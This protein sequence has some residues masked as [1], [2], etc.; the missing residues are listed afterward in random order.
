MSLSTTAAT[1]Q[2]EINAS[3]ALDATSTRAAGWLSACP[4]E[5]S[6]EDCIRFGAFKFA[7]ALLSA[8]A[9]LA[10]GLGLKGVLPCAG[11]AGLTDTP[12][13][14]SSG[15]GPPLPQSCGIRRHDDS[16]CV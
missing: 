8:S 3:M 1:R 6:S 2:K 5:F 16:T 10:D 15:E 13:G 11:W 7:N 4:W 12:R 14:I 9:R